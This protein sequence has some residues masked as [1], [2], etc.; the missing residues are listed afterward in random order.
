MR[1]YYVFLNLIKK[2]KGNDEKIDANT[3][4]INNITNSISNIADI[5]YPVGSIY[6]SVSGTANPETLFGGTWVRLENR[7]LLG[8]GSQNPLG[9]TGG[10]ERVTLSSSE[11]PRHRHRVIGGE[12]NITRLRSSRGWYSGNDG[13]HWGPWFGS[14]YS[15]SDNVYTDYAGAS[16]STT[17]SH[18]NMPPFLV[19]N[20]WKR[21]A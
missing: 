2:I 13:D 12:D 16:S 17:S 7:F 15:G 4:A 5:V 8:A 14:G 1:A 3:S 19:V 20:M 18:E 11:V 21:T 6:M 9:G 10:S